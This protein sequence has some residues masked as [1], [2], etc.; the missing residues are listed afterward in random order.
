MRSELLEI[1]ERVKTIADGVERGI[2][3]EHL[4]S[5][6][7]RIL[8]AARNSIHREAFRVMVFGDFSSGKS[9]LIN[10]LLGEDILP[11]SAN[12]TTAFTTVVSRADERS[13][14]L[15]RDIEN[16]PEMV[17]V[18]SIEEFQRQ[19]ELRL[20]EEGQT[21]RSPY[22][23]GAVYGPFPILSAGVELIDSAGVNEDPERERVTMNYLPLVDAVI[24]VTLAKAAFKQQDQNYY[25]DLLR[26]HG[27]DDIFFRGQPGRRDRRPGSRGRREPVPRHRAED[28]SPVRP[29]DLL[30]QC[31]TGAVSPDRPR[32][33]G[34][35]SGLQRT[36][37]GGCSAGVLPRRP[38][39]AEATKAS[40]GCPP[41]DL[42]A[43]REGPQAARG[44]GSQREGPA[45]Y[46]RQQGRGTAQH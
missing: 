5:T 10:A 35:G 11:R 33:G 46:P 13:A 24:Y 2:D 22:V 32:E 16:S 26:K 37:A 1:F 23:H 8:E 45:H 39:S 15:S 20:D 7:S 38:R 40:R 12:P 31:E 36:G 14:R 29:Q 21:M 4:P 3:H 17:D 30:H 41:R 27:H 9:T 34:S 42:Q 25:L 28:E 18:V 6:Q 44:A 19:V 43:E